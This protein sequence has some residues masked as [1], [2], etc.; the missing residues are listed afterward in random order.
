MTLALVAQRAG[1]SVQTVSNALNSPDLLAPRT[2]ARV[3]EALSELDY[4]PHQ[5]ARSLRTRSSRL[6]GYGVQPMPAGVSTPVHDDF[7]HA[8]SDSADRAGYRILL[9]AASAD[10]E[11]D[12]Y[13]EL[14][15]EHSV[16]AFVLSNTNRGDK[17]PAW[18]L[19]RDVPFV[20]FGRSWSAREHGDWVDVDGA[21]GTAAAVGH[22]VAAGHRRIAFL[23]WPRGSGVGDDRARGWR[24]AMREHALPTRDLRV[25]SVNDVD[26]AREAVA[27]VLARATAVVAAS[28]TLALGC[29]R[30]L[31]DR[32]LS[33]GRD[34]AVVGFD[35]SPAAA[36]LAPALSSVRQPL[37]EVGRACIGL[38]M[39]RI[40]AP[41]GAAQ[42]VLLPPELVVRESSVPLPPA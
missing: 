18:L 34:V 42:H 26:A 39:D 25:S 11:A 33:P 27:P 32:D 22:L 8:L 12:R 2:L 30:A 21:H 14:L 35:D 24:E 37:R 41:G 13:D 6:I 17:R 9:F 20:A 5:A 40:S 28:D 36:L 1:V 3:N 19:K 38:L 10:G 31:R 29:Y 15:R 16:D 4:R 23:G 7:L